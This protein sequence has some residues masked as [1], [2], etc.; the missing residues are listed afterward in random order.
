L[1]TKL[2]LPGEFRVNGVSL[3]PDNAVAKVDLPCANTGVANTLAA[4]STKTVEGLHFLNIVR[5]LSRV[6]MNRS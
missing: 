4:R 2:P 1:A 3:Y 6:L 5:S